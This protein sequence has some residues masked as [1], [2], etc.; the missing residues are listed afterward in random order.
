MLLSLPSHRL[1]PWDLHFPS[2]FLVAVR[3]DFP[4]SLQRQCKA[5]KQLQASGVLPLSER[6]QVKASYDEHCQSDAG[7]PFNKV[8]QM[9]GEK[10]ALL[11]N[12]IQIKMWKI[13]FFLISLKPCCKRLHLTGGEIKGDY[14]T[15]KEVQ[16]MA[17]K[18][19]QCLGRRNHMRRSFK[20]LELLSTER[21]RWEGNRLVWYVLLEGM[22]T[23]KQGIISQTNPLIWGHEVTLRYIRATSF[24]QVHWMYL[25][26]AYVWFTLTQ[27]NLG[28]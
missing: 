21:Q 27:G 6:G 18:T 2:S 24:G 28:V 7:N 17:M 9:L 3:C 1:I 23:A 5:E 13:F 15:R 12:L 8:M 19:T 11:Q 4:W 16:S 25:C 10:E 14:Y 22:K 26:H 20:S